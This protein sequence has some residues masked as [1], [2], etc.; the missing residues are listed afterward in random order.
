MRVETLKSKQLHPPRNN[1]HDA[2]K[3][4]LQMGFPKSK[5]EHYKHFGLNALLGFSISSENTMQLREHLEASLVVEDGKFFYIPSLEGVTCKTAES[6]TLYKAHYDDPF[7]H[8]S[9]AAR[10]TV[11]QIVITKDTNFSLEHFL[12][13]SAVIPYR[14]ALHVSDGVH[15]NFFETYVT[16]GESQNLSLYG[17]DLY[18]G[19]NAT[20]KWHR[21]HNTKDND[22]FIAT[23]SVTLEHTATFDLF[24]YDFGSGK[25]LHR[26][27]IDLG[28][29]ATFNSQQLVGAQ[30]I[31]NLGNGVTVNHHFKEAASHQNARY[32]LKDKST[33]IFDGL[34]N[35]K[36]DAIKTKA[37]Q[38]CKSILLSDEGSAKMAGKPHLKI[39]TDDLEAS[40]GLSI[41]TLDEQALF[42]LRSRGVSTD[43]AK[44]MLVKAFAKEPI[45]VLKN[46]ALKEDVTVSLEAFLTKDRL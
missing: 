9:H 42:Y 30:K 31:G 17:I 4:F 37:H 40:H 26:F 29:N 27:E 24:T 43:E 41:G 11:L 12:S 16:K 15:V 46:Q 39:H 25:A 8:Y 13:G 21:H 5:D 7:Y 32:I 2:F 38:N 10:S 6:T 36:S 34:V 33:G 19:Q 35:V 3:K 14:I 23:H 22:A 28:Q 44:A 1:T 45:E 20:L 18:I